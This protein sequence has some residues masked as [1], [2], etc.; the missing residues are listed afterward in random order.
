MTDN[1][2]KLAEIERAQ[3]DWARDCHR[4]AGVPGKPG[5]PLANLANGLLALRS[6]P[7]FKGMF[8]YDEMLRAPMLVRAIDEPAETFKPRPLTDVDVGK[9]QEI[10]QKLGLVRLPKDIAHQAV[11]VVAHERRFHPVRDYLKGLAWDGTPRLHCWLSTYLGAEATEYIEKIGAMF[12]ISM[13]AR[14]FDP[15]SKV[16]H[17]LVVEGP[18]GEMKSTACSILGGKWFS[19]SLPEITGGKDVSMHLRGK[20]LIEIGE[21][22]ATS[23]AEATLLKSFISRTH[24]QYRPS[25][26]RREVIEPRQCV[27]VGTTNRDT[28]LKDETGGR[29]FWPI[30]AGAIKIEAIARD[31]DQLFAEAV[32]LY[33]DGVP[34][35]PDRNFEREQ[36]MPQQAD[37]C[38]NDAWEENIAAYL[39]TKD[40]VLVGEVA[41]TA[42]Y[43]ETPRIGTADQRRITAVMETLGWHRLPVD[44][45]GKR[46]WGPR[47]P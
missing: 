6:D 26:G 17:M 37:R 29:R 43:I 32:R 28:Y 8:V 47:L 39:K 30:K 41:R 4:G 34:W 18:Q 36:I 40:R 42:L 35:W 14:I 22:H 9:I 1:I 21:L 13:V 33:R 15:G 2:I 27:F 38:E 45:Q 7:A 20:W 24:E 23:R 16:D 3:P 12:M 19:D 44:W 10:L 31:R 25:Y 5:K 46:W 11:D